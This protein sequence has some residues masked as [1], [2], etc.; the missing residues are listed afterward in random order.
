MINM[1]NAMYC[2]KAHTV[3]NDKFVQ[4]FI[5]CSIKAFVAI[6]PLTHFLVGGVVNEDGHDVD[7]E[8]LAELFLVENGPAKLITAHQTVLVLV[9]LVEGRV[10]NELLAGLLRA[11]VLQQAVDVLD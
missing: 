11:L 6:I 9:H 5:K 1:A 2:C 7:G 8:Q 3:L 10:G 4:E